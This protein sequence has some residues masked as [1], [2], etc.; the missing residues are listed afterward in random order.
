MDTASSTTGIPLYDSEHDLLLDL[1]R[2]LA[3]CLLG[4]EGVDAFVSGF[5]ELLDYVSELF[6]R[7]EEAM[8]DRDYADYQRHRHAHV[9]LLET[10]A[11]LLHTASERFEKYDCYA[12]LLFIRHWIGNHIRDHDK[13]LAQFLLNPEGPKTS[14][15]TSMGLPSSDF[16]FRA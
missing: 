3:A 4:S 5:Q 9:K 15:V 11:D 8:Q 13:P 16:T 14:R 2:R 10:G 6:E 1:Y 12:M 7:E